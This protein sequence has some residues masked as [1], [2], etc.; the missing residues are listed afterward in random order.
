MLC[1]GATLSVLGANFDDGGNY[2]QAL[3]DT[4]FNDYPLINQFGVNLLSAVRNS[5]G[6]LQTPSYNY[7][8]LRYDANEN[9]AALLMIALIWAIYLAFLF[10]QVILALN[11]LIAIVSDTY[12][13]IN[14]RRL[15]AII[16]SRDEL[17]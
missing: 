9:V 12:A 13:E 10:I 1:F 14:D 8:M 17:N 15:E 16:T 3:Y 6:D 2:D 4:N 11:F 7:W 5:I